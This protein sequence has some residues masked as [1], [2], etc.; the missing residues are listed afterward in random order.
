MILQPSRQNIMQKSMNQKEFSS[1]DES[2]GLIVIGET[3]V[4]VHKETDH[5]LKVRKFDNL[6]DRLFNV[7]LGMGDTRVWH[8]MPNS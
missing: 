6:I 7:T 8:T 1:A 4:T 5:E 3:V 2:R